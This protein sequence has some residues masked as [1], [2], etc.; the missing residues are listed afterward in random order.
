MHP[1]EKPK[2]DYTLKETS[3]DI[4]RGKVTGSD[5]LTLVEQRQFLYVRIVRA[6]E[7]PVNDET[8]TCDPFVELMIGKEK[9]TSR[10]LEKTS[11][12]EW[13]QVFAFAKDRLHGRVVDILIR[14][15]GSANDG[16][17]GCVSFDLGDIPSR[18]PPDSPLAPQWY[19][20]EDQQ[21]KSVPGELM[22][23][24]WIGNQAD[25]AFSIAW[26]SDAAAVSGENVTY[27]RSK[28]YHS[29]RLWYLRIHVIAAQ[30]L[31]PTDKNRKPEAF[32]KAILG[33]LV[34]RSKVSNVKNVN[35]TWNEELMFV[36]AEPFNDPLILS[37]EDKWGANKEEC[38]GRC[39]IHL[40]QVDKRL[41]PSSMADRWVNL[42]NNGG[43]FVSRLHLR[44]YL[45]GVYHVFDEPT[46]YCSDLRPTSPKLWPD[47]IGILEVGILKAEGLLPMKS[48]D[49]RGTT[50]AYCVAK[51]GNKWIRTTT[52]IDNLSPK[53]NEQY[54]WDVYDP[55]TVI[56][57]GVF[58]NSHLQGVG[59]KG[60][61]GDPR[62][63][64]VRIRLSTLETDRIYTHSYPLIVLQPN[65]LKKTGEL[66][67]AVKF[68]CTSLVN[69]LQTYAHPLLPNMHYISPLSVYQLDSLRHQATHILSSRLGR[70]DHLN[71]WSLRRGK[72][73]CERVISCLTGM[74]GIWRWFDHVRTWKSPSTTVSVYSL[75]VLMVI[76]PRLTLPIFFFTLFFV[77]VW[78]FPRRPRHPPHMDIKL[79]N[80]EF[81]H[82]D[83][84][85]EEFDT[86][87]TSKQGDVLKARYDRLRNIA[88][89]L[90]IMI[91]DLATQ[92]ERLRSLL[93]WRDP[94]A[95]FIFM[96]CCLIAGCIFYISPFQ[97]M[98]VLAGTYAIRP[99]RMRSNLPSIPQNFLRRL[100]AKTESLL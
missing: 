21:G 94:R 7:L 71:M 33:N 73:N 62:I 65:G 26:H 72:A 70:A 80:A 14:D 79:S 13:N 46:Y 20:L 17:I 95:T 5:K 100:P 69:L 54:Y 49:G 18:F 92:M 77:G 32:V 67:L 3:P 59:K 78:S 9:G 48:K 63:G 6:K 23:A 68:N 41:L 98:V 57:V 50:D 16:S 38:L 52:I 55:Y 11:N 82:P 96:I 34:S 88:G 66:H 93:S 22:L 29:P 75:F 37:V 85:D 42:E 12:P 83:E 44:V 99:P 31:A 25:D 15:K 45:D 8:G 27:T 51:Y 86:F 28:V 87:P 91:G 36:A 19:R 43:K 2:E 89:R 64:K 84:L 76:M 47:K 61:S 1:K 56:T 53:W 74:L 58:D 35:P 24:V 90:M 39:V 40:Q 4:S 60:G 97:Y 81:T 10:I 30:D